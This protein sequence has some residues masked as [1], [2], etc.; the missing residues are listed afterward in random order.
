M[1]NKLVAGDNK[2]FAAY[3]FETA[4]NPSTTTPGTGTFVAGFSTSNS[5]DVSPNISGDRCR[6]GGNPLYDPTKA[7]MT[8]VAGSSSWE[9]MPCDENS[10]CPEFF[11][12]GPVNLKSARYCVSTG[13]STTSFDEQYENNRI[14]GKRQADKAKQLFDSLNAEPTTPVN[15]GVVPTTGLVTGNINFKHFFVNMEKVSVSSTY[16]SRGSGGSINAPKDTCKAGFGHSF[17]AGG[18]DG[19]NG[20]DVSSGVFDSLQGWV[21]ISATT[22]SDPLVGVPIVGLPYSASLPQY[23]SLGNPIRPIWEAPILPV[24]IFFTALFLRIAIVAV[25]MS[26][27]VALPLTLLLVASP[28]NF[29]LDDWQ[30]DRRY[31]HGSKK[32]MEAVGPGGLA[33][34][35]QDWVHRIVPYQLVKIGQIY[36]ASVPGEITT[37]AGRRL[38][39]SIQTDLTAQGL[40]TTGVNK[41]IIAGYANSYIHYITTYE[42]YGRQRYEGGS[43]IFG[44]HELGGNIYMKKTII[45]ICINNNYFRL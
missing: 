43:T 20:D 28:W 12:L 42:E 39:Q 4:L 31:C 35:D 29:V 45:V 14:I 25:P 19:P 33:G 32:L 2:G 22:Q 1:S 18:T 44:P 17:A 41:V 21:G 37:M 5:G 38:K 10:A 7:P 13:P 26:A 40:W 8:L 23:N 6:Y 30:V 34:R 11:L 24:A 16:V 36:M 27:V 3:I 9:G 15:N